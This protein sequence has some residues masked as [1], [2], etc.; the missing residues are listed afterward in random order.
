[1]KREGHDFPIQK[2]S[3]I[4]SFFQLAVIIFQ[5]GKEQARKIVTL[6]NPA[7]STS[8][9][10]QE[11]SRSYTTPIIQLPDCSSVQLLNC[12]NNEAMEPGNN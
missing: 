2:H 11:L 12:K 4:N 8:L 3:L 1:R 9:S 6:C 10:E 7:L 5:P